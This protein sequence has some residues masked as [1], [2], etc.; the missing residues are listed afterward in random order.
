MDRRMNVD[1]QIDRLTDKAIPMS[2][3]NFTGS[4]QYNHTCGV[5]SLV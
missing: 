1:E 3:L 4:Y 2:N 5:I